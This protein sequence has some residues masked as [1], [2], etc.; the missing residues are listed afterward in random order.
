MK[1]EELILIADKGYPD[2]KVKEAFDLMM[3]EDELVEPIES[4][5]GDT[6]A[7]FV[8]REISETFDPEAKDL[9]QIHEA[10]RVMAVAQNEIN[11]VERELLKAYRR[12]LCHE[13]NRS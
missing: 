9:S 11:Q 7:I 2:G 13:K 8:A 3:V 10:V 12:T 4:Q 1:L 6:L 5:V